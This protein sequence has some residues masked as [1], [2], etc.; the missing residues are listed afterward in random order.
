MNTD[1]STNNIYKICTA[2][3]VT[4]AF[5]HTLQL[6]QINSQNGKTNNFLQ[7]DQ[8]DDMQKK[9]VGGFDTRG[10]PELR[11]VLAVRAVVEPAEYP[12]RLVA[13]LGQQNYFIN[14]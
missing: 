13:R 1:S 14:F 2:S 10:L 7:A 12:V 6:Q 3:K 11:S 5:H 8:K 9:V 4:A